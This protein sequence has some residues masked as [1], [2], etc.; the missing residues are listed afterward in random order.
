MVVSAIP[1]T[2]PDTRPLMQLE[3][4]NYVSSD[5]NELYRKIIM[6]N[7]T[8]ESTI[9]NEAP[10]RIIYEQKRNLQM[11][12]D[13]LF[14]SGVAKTSSGKTF[15]SITDYLKGKTG[16]F[17]QNLLG[18]R[19]DFSARSAIVGGPDLKMYEAG[20]P[21]EIALKIFRPF[22]IAKLISDTDANGEQIQPIAENI[23]DAERIL[24]Q[25]DDRI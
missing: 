18:K 16:L 19:V 21:V 1:V 20:V 9:A 22:I 8:L 7:K 2:P 3:T 12:V 11:A 10:T 6:R 23:K 5:I 17:R 13:E 15:K 25:R 24:I 4:G 14:D